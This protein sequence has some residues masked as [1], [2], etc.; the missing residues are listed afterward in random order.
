MDINFKDYNVTYGVDSKSRAAIYI[1]DEQGDYVLSP[2][3]KQIGKQMPGGIKTARL[4]KLR[5]A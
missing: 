1:V 4:E 5:I 3:E 2:D